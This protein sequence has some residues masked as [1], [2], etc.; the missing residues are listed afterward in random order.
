MTFNAPILLGER[1]GRSRV[2]SAVGVSITRSGP[3]SNFQRAFRAQALQ[4]TTD[5]GN[6]QAAITPTV[7]LGAVARFRRTVQHDVIEALGVPDV[8][9][10]DIVVLA[11]KEWDYGEWL[12]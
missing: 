1:V 9:D 12:P 4:V 5:R 10:R 7:G 3:R 2:A 8:I 11:P 6:C